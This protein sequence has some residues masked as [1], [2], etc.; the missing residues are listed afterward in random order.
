V[1]GQV[2]GQLVPIPIK[3]HHAEY[4]VQPRPQSDD[5][6][7]AFLATRAEPVDVIRTSRDVVVSAVGE[8]LYQ[9]FFE[10]YTRKQWGIDPSEL[11]KAVTAACRP[12]Q[13]RTT[14]TSPTSTSHAAARLYQDVPEDARHPNITVE[15]GVDWEDMKRGVTWDHLVF[16]GPVDE[17]FG[18]RFGKLPT[19]RCSSTPQLNQEWYQPVAVVNYPHPEVPY[20]RITE[21]QV[22]HRQEAPNTPSRWSI[23]ARKAIRIIRSRVKRTRCCT[24][25]TQLL[26]RAGGCQL[27]RPLAT[28][29]YY[30]M[31]QVVGQ[32]LATY[33]RLM[34][35]TTPAPAV[36][37][38][39]RQ[40]VRATAA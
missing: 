38:S 28:Y 10:G 3:S 20:T 36:A 25:S 17:F 31:D 8:H 26:R 11:D 6:A 7:A 9:L 4:A 24:R 23:P 5:D 14:A 39:M 22:P 32:A 30:N 16:T 21:I 1:L 27:C 19:A 33:R 40:A 34:E 2:E 18:H 35:R 29:R 13:L 37:S 12:A 15:L